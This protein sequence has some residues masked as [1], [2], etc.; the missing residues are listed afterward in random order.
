M[1]KTGFNISAKK[2][3]QITFE[4]GWTASVQFGLSNYCHNG[5][6]MTKTS[7]RGNRKFRKQETDTAAPDCP[8][9][10]VAA[11]ASRD[12]WHRFSADAND[13]VKGWVSPSEVVAFLQLV[14]GFEPWSGE[15]A[16]D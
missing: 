7:E 13:T 8:T 5:F 4:N 15:S 3:F 11:F 2:G 1:T 10:E 14:E 16:R 12:H 9:A 6:M